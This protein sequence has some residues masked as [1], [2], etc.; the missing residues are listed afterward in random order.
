MVF[1][2]EVD[3]LVVLIGLCGVTFLMLVLT[4]A[5]YNIAVGVGIGVLLALVH[6]VFRG[7]DDLFLV[8]DNADGA[9]AMRETA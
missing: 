4:H 1:G 6:A 3:D 7:T 8:D 9:T 2:Q 5:S